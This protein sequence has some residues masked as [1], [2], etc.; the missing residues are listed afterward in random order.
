MFLA[1]RV[2][3]SSFFYRVSNTRM[4]TRELPQPTQIPLWA[5]PSVDCEYLSQNCKEFNLKVG[6]NES[7]AS[8]WDSKEEV[9][10]ICGL[11]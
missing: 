8:N 10:G 3:F 4:T 5:S 1:F 6:G 2:F 11:S 9:F 7:G